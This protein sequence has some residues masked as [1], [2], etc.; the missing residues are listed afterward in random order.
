MPLVSGQA[1]GAGP[2]PRAVIFDLDGTLVDSYDAIAECFNHAR[3]GLGEAPLAPDEVR[4]L[5]GHGL[6]ALMID[7]VGPARAPAAV[8]L[9][10]ERYDRVCESR[11]RV[12]P[13]V[14][15]TLRRLDAAGWRLGVATNKPTSFA[16]R[17]VRAL[18]LAPPIAAVAGPENGV[19]PKPEPEMLRRVL[20]ELGVESAAA[21]YV[22]DMAL[23]VESGR[24]AG[25][26]V[27]LVPTGSAEAGALAGA[28]ADRL[29]PDFAALGTL[30]APPRG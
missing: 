19:P 24:R 1:K 12:L 2:R 13:G 21:I 16:W 29:L 25:L 30:L 18:G 22:G 7:A 17:I 5:V 9:F 3:T 11:T 23:D 27:W 8:R 15:A 14:T 10:R 4:R 6:E 20:R 26:P 28:G